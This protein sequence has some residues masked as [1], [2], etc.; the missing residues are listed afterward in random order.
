MRKFEL[1]KRMEWKNCT[2]T[3]KTI[4]HCIQKG[5]KVT[6]THK[7]HTTHAH[8][9]FIMENNC[10]IVKVFEFFCVQIECENYTDTFS[11]A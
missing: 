2:Y 6:H 4:T 7:K 10:E 8:T 11:G 5:D 9:V 3:H 1:H